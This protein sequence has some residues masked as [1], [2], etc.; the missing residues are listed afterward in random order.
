M[1]TIIPCL[2]GRTVD[3]RR[4]LDDRRRFNPRPREGANCQ[5]AAKFDPGSACKIDPDGHRFRLVPVANRR[6]PRAS[7]SA[8]T[9]DE[10][11]RVGGCLFA[12]RGKPGWY[13]GAVLK[14]P[15]LVTGLD[16]FAVMGQAVE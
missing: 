15:A 13:S 10:A 9:S 14:S 7:R 4:G 11:T 6:A 2:Q 12:H 16:D 1:P 8:L 3:R 5:S